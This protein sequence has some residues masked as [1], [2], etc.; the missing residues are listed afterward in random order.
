MFR[1]NICLLKRSLPYTLFSRNFQ[2]SSSSELLSIAVL[3]DYAAKLHYQRLEKCLKIRR[4]HLHM[5]YRIGLLN[6]RLKR[7]EENGNLGVLL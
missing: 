7:F 2:S 5:L 1:Y 3:K 6:K 4:K